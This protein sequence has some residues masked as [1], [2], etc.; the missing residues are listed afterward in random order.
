MDRTNLR[1]IHTLS[2]LYPQLTGLIIFP[3]FRIEE[4][5]YLAGAGHLLPTGSTRFIISPR[6]LHV[7]YPLSELGAD[8]SLEEKN[9]NLNQWL[10]DR[11][12]DKKVRYY[13]E[14]TFLFDE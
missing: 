9:A 10:Q 1:D 6:A 7:N 2:V 3:G 4:V 13:Q 5:L 8:T 14:A 11:L 12:T